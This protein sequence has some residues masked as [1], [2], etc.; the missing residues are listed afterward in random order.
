[1]SRICIINNFNSLIDYN[2]IDEDGYLKNL[3]LIK[4]TMG[5]DEPSKHYIIKYDRKERH[6]DFCGLFRSCVIYDNKL[7]SYSPQKSVPFE[8]LRGDVFCIE[9]FV[10]GT[11]INVYYVNGEWRLSTRS[12]IGA[13]GSFYENDTS[14]KTMFYDCKKL[15]GLEYHHLN[16]NYSYSFLVQHPKNRIVKRIYTPTLYLCGV[17]EITNDVEVKVY[18]ISIY[19]EAQRIQS[20]LPQSMFKLR[21]PFLYGSGDLELV[22]SYKNL[23]HDSHNTR[24]D[25]MGIIVKD[26]DGNRAKYRNPAYEYVRQLRGNQ[27]KLE[28]QYLVLRHTGKVKEFLKYYPEYK[29]YFSRYRE[30]VH[31]YTSNLYRYYVEC[32]IKHANPIQEFPYEYRN[33]M[34]GLH[35][36][37]IK[38]KMKNIE[39]K[40]SITFRDV[41][42]YVNNLEPPRLMYCLNYKAH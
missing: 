20:L 16:K 23:Y 42:Q 37:Y 9:E 27:P 21:T 2:R 36:L 29:T 18:S 13:E 19:T 31:T 30:L 8:K 41:V 26:R 4:S 11:M 28:Y 6:D 15:I 17:Y 3:N 33:H 10:E 34:V 12:I 25:I 24:Y 40:K 7:V 22:K 39:I 35:E 38:E 32:F 5:S 14:F 1:M